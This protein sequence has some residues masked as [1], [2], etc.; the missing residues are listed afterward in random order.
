MVA[1]FEHVKRLIRKRIGSEIERNVLASE[2]DHARARYDRAA[3]ILT[4]IHA[5]LNPPIVTD[6]DGKKFVFRSP[7]AHEQIQELSDRIRA[8]PDEIA[9]IE[10][11]VKETPNA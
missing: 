1:N 11:D 7:L 6:S 10:S 5:L 8:I 3:R 9:A 4:G 2:R